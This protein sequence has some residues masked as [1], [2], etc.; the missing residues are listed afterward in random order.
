MILQVDKIFK[1][2]S[3]QKEQYKNLTFIELA[4]FLERAIEN[5]MKEILTI[6]GISCHIKTY[7][8]N[9]SYKSIIVFK[10]KYREMWLTNGFINFQD[11][12]HKIT[13]ELLNKDYDKLRFNI[14][15]SITKLKPHLLIYDYHDFEFQFKYF[16]NHRK[17]ISNNENTENPEVKN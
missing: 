11:C 16:G 14:S 8:N 10:E 1:E 12:F 5:D 17:N 6:L 7:P 13:K 3:E 4:P 15:I 9:I 2:Y